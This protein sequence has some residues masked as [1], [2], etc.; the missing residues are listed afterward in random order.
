MTLIATS[1]NASKLLYAV[2]S[3]TTAWVFIDAASVL[4]RLT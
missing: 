1:T 2:V 3:M 4:S